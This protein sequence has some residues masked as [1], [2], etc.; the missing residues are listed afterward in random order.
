MRSI[1]PHLLMAALLL[2]IC[3]ACAS[4]EQEDHGVADRSDFIRFVETGPWEGRLQT[5]VVSYRNP[6][7]RRVDLVAAVHLAD[8]AYYGIL[9]GLFRIYDAVLYELVAPEGTRP[10]PER[11]A[12]NLVSR[13]QMGLC[14]TLGLT[15][16]LQAVDYSPHNFVHADLSPGRLAQVWKESGETAI[17]VLFRVLQ[18]Q[19]KS[20]VEGGA[21][22]LTPEVMLDA[23]RDPQWRK[24]IKFLVARELAAQ[25]GF[26]SALDGEE[27]ERPFILIGERNKAVVEVLRR[28]LG[29]GRKRIAVFYGAGHMK[30]MERRI[31]RTFGFRRYAR[32]WITAWEISPGKNGSKKGLS[33]GEKD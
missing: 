4:K 8:P 1:F 19:M 21:S 18:A 25:M 2:T 23:L 5:A 29:R 9:Q 15:F 16:Q 10:R 6:Q 26:L 12:D 22:A 30:D 28:E 3:P 11:K 31:E 13:F 20:A 17:S 33:S 14:R 27:G 32:E 24:R 7:G